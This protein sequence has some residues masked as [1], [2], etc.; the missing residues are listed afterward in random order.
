M[1][2]PLSR[3]MRSISG[4]LAVAEDPNHLCDCH[5][6][7]L[8]AEVLSLSLDQ[9]AD[10]H[11]LDHLQSFDWSTAVMAQQAG[12][13]AK[14]EHCV[15]LSRQLEGSEAGLFLSSG[16]TGDDVEQ[17]LR[18]QILE[19]RVH[20]QSIDLGIDDRERAAPSYALDSVDDAPTRITRF[21]RIASRDFIT[22]SRLSH[23][24]IQ[25]SRATNDRKLV[26][27]MGQRRLTIDLGPISA[28]RSPSGKEASL[29]PRDEFNGLLDTIAACIG[30]IIEKYSIA[31]SYLFDMFEIS[32]S[33]WLGAFDLILGVRYSLA[34]L[35]DDFVHMEHSKC[36][37]LETCLCKL[38]STIEQVIE[39]FSLSMSC[40]NEAHL[41]EDISRQEWQSNSVFRK[42]QRVSYGVLFQMQ[43]MIGIIS[44]LNSY[45]SFSSCVGGSSF[46]SGFTQYSKPYFLR[47]SLEVISSTADSIFYI[48]K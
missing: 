25:I 13:L 30:S 14:L 34:G 41:L 31:C 4:S 6:L 39:R 45:V 9:P 2:P 18:T 23:I 40:A 28:T 19:D 12:V 8:L 20:L 1:E 32:P 15:A 16:D 38:E 24:S 11:E 21:L 7:S 3:L 5:S 26:A 33:E 27:L 22:L 42:G 10:S 36:T 44:D 35:F 37:N 46:H 29:E 17:V 48:Y 47:L 43:T